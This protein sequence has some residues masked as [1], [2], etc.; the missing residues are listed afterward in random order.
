MRVPEQ[1]NLKSPTEKCSCIFG[2]STIHGGRPGEI[3][4]SRLFPFSELEGEQDSAP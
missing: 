1:L 3:P 4:T 2:T